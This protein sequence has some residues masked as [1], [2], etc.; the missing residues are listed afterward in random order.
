MTLD[1]PCDLLCSTCCLAD[2]CLFR[3]EE[4]KWLIEQS[5]SSQ[6]IWANKILFLVEMLFYFVKIREV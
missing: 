4:T 5:D 3:N 1:L 2:F 6:V